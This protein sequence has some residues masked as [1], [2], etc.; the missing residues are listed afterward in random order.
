MSIIITENVYVWCEQFRCVGVLDGRHG[1]GTT[2]DPYCALHD[3]LRGR[4]PEDSAE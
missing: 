3:M 2:L 4:L 1:C